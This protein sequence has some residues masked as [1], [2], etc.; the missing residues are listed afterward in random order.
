MSSE[1]Y[2]NDLLKHLVKN[3]KDI[4]SSFDEKKELWK[5]I[6]RER[7]PEPLSEEVLILEDKFLRSELLNKIIFTTSSMVSKL[8]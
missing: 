6:V 8:K 1:E 7:K 4:P 2:L 5:K 3:K